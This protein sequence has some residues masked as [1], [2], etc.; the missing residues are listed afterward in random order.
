MVVDVTEPDGSDTWS[1]CYDRHVLGKVA[2]YLV[3]IG[4]DQHNA[5]SKTERFSCKL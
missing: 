2:D 1:L 4:Y 3:F 5:S